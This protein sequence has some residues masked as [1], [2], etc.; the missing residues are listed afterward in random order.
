[1]NPNKTIPGTAYRDFIATKAKYEAHARKKLNQIKP[2]YMFAGA[3][4][5]AEEVTLIGL[6][7]GEKRI[8]ISV[9]EFLKDIA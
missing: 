2:G 1:M 6:M 5:G 4:F 8:S 3:Y 9:G 7:G